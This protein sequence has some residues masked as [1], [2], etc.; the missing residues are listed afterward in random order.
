MD[1]ETAI[2]ITREEYR[3]LEIDDLK[4]REDERHKL[5]MRVV[6]VCEYGN[7]DDLKRLNK[8]L[9]DNNFAKKK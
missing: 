1:L 9:E 6:D 8:L 7:L 4:L 2:S 5:M 3:L